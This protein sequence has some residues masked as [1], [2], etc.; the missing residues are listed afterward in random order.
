MGSVEECSVAGC[1]RPARAKGWCLPHYKRAR[2]WGDPLGSAVVPLVE[3]FVAKVDRRGP[4][5]CWPWTSTLDGDG[6]GVISVGRG[7]SNV[8]AHRLAYFLAVGPTELTLDHRCHTRDLSC[9]GGPTCPHRRCANPA[10][11]EPTT[12][13]DNTSMGHGP[14]MAIHAT[15][16]CARGHLRSEHGYERKDRPGS[17]NCRE[18]RRMAR[19]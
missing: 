5:E 4:D 2:R 18:C 17:F 6:Y 19:R 12:R 15:D 1:N 9:P 10:H 14:T 16:S 7:S 8:R 13:A 3:R 11:L